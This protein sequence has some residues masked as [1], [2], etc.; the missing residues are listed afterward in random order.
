MD[1]ITIASSD[2][3]GGVVVGALVCGTID[4]RGGRRDWKRLYVYTEDACHGH[5]TLSESHNFATPQRLR[6]LPLRE[7]LCIIAK[8][9]E[10]LKS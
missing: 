4:S 10:V 6:L 3:N 5:V 2:D 8:L 7:S 1:K 9:S